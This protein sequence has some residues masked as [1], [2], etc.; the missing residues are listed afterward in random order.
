[1]MLLT[2]QRWEEAAGMRW[3]EISADISVWTMKGERTTN[4]KAKLA[5]DTALMKQGA[6][7]SAKALAGP[8]RR[9]S[10]WR[11]NQVTWQA[12]AAFRL[13]V[14]RRQANHA[15][16]TLKA[17]VGVISAARFWPSGRPPQWQGVPMWPA[18][19][20]AQWWRMWQA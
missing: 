2:A 11:H 6:E 5:L 12:Q 20:Q 7:D 9:F 3:S 8:G 10:D 19:R 14:A 15:A 18:A 17:P 13:N 16:D 1:M 4:G